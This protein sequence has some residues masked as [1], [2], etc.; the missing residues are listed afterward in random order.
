MIVRNERTV[1]RRCLAS[2]LPLIDY[3]VVVDT[4][5]SDGTPEVVIDCLRDVPGEL[6]RRPWVDFAH[7]RN[8]ALDYA[9]GRGDY[10]FVID[11]DEVLEIDAGFR[12]SLLTGD[13]YFLESRFSGL[14]YRRRQ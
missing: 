6:F 13:A 8:E 4:G 1:I 9:Q 5:S 10:V 12:K 11:A 2:V 7:N 3:W 14:V